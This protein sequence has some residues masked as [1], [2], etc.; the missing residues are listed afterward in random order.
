MGFIKRLLLKKD[1]TP[2]VFIPGIMGSLGESILPGTGGYDFGLSEF[3]YRPMINMLE[4]MGY[5]EE[6]NLFIAYY[7]WRESNAYSAE[8]YLIPMIEKAKKVTRK[9]KVNII[10]HSMG[11]IVTRYYIQ[12][13]NYKKDINKFIMIATPNYGSVNAY[14]FWSGGHLPYEDVERNIFYKLLKLG[15]LFIFKLK[16]REKSDIK[17]IRKMVPSVKELLPTYEYG[18]YLF[19]EDK[20]K[21]KKYVDIYEMAEKNEFLNS[22]NKGKGTFKNKGIK[23]YIIIGTGVETDTHICIRE[24][25]QNREKWKDGKPI[26]AIKTTLGD[27]TVTCDSANFYGKKI[28]I[29]SSHTDILYDCKYPLSD[30]LNT[31]IPETTDILEYMSYNTIYSMILINISKVEIKHSDDYIIATEHENFKSEKVVIRRIDENVYWI[32]IRIK[33][34]KANISFNSIKNGE[35]NIILFK[36]DKDKGTISKEN[37]NIK[38][39]MSLS[40]E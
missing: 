27:G 13:D 17:L 26:Y 31:S 25:K 22:L 21:N 11:G 23:N 12:S 7:N 33:D 39:K 3:V 10:S 14:Y 37:I 40:L 32:M 18:D 16:N 38:S 34:D 9:N 19:I 5:K 2:I 28:Y 4:R 30:I 6:E 15:F 8:N 35:G 1:D 20:E 24:P 29:N 36:G